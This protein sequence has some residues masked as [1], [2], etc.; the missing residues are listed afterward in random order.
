MKTSP[1]ERP[2]TDRHLWQIQPVRDLFWI[3]LGVLLLLVLY[4]LREIFVPM[5]FA[6]LLAYLFVP[7]VDAAERRLRFRPWLTISLI[8]LGMLGALVGLGVWLGPLIVDQVIVLAEQVPK[9][10][11]ALAHRLHLPVAAVSAED[12]LKEFSEPLK[13]N[14]SSIL[15]P[16]LNVSGETLGV[17]AGAIGVTA[18]I[19][20][21]AALFPIYF[22]CFALKFHRI[23]A[24]VEKWVPA[25]KRR[26]T[27][28]ILR[29]MDQVVGSYVRGRLLVSGI[30]T[31]G[32][33][34]GWS[35]LL[36][37]VPYWLLLAVLAGLLSLVPYAAIVAYLCV[38][39]A[40]AVAIAELPHPTLW[41]W[42]I[43]LAAPTIV[44]AVVQGADHWPLTPWVQSRSTDL[45]VLTVVI[46]VVVGGA[47]AGILGML[48]A[49]P[50]TACAKILVRELLL[51]P[52]ERR[53]DTS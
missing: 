22:F 20:V 25:S 17:I 9:D 36:A 31:A 30:M 46:A 40:K 8:L 32:F 27:N 11:L 1:A 26:R 19:V 50:V 6:F 33:A 13:K 37:D 38:L 12:L 4:Y 44:Y 49:I 7:L 21:T 52:W 5:L 41:T 53:A 2:W 47:V 45:S 10:L 18:Y 28:D 43:G 51:S 15:R 39:L 48:V 35:P 23:V 29:Q 3:G 24:R 34:L 42:I 14:P 16:L